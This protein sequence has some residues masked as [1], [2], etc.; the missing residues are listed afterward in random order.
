MPLW[1]AGSP[2]NHV[3]FNRVARL[4]VPLG[5]LA[6]AV[7]FWFAHPTRATL[8][9]GI[10]VAAAGEAFRF[11]AAGHLNKSQEVTTSGPY[12]L[13]AHPLYVGSSVMGVGLTIAS[14][15]VC[16]AVLVA[17]YLGVTLTAAVKSEEAF[18]RE[19][20]GDGYERYRRGAAMEV[21][22]RRR[23]S[24]ERALANREHRAL[25]GLVLAVLLLAL[26]ARHGI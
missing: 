25:A 10:S 7:A 20:F 5:F 21:G 9:A 24:F 11:W 6:G 23:F 17:V 22:E 26:R 3:M 12:R 18:L 16:V 13:C 15:S 4:R 1:I 14:G 19:K 8:I 2:L